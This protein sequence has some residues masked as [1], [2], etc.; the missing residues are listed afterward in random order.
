MNVDIEG[1]GILLAWKGRGSGTKK[2]EKGE[3]GSKKLGE[4]GKDGGGHIDYKFK[5]ETRLHTPTN[6]NAP[7]IVTKVTLIASSFL[8]HVRTRSSPA[9]PHHMAAACASSAS[10]ASPH[11]A[12]I[13]ANHITKRTGIFP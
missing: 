9:V 11:T 12:E 7:A 3:K 4:E 8:A 13:A 2:K 10:V 1:E 6:I 5:S